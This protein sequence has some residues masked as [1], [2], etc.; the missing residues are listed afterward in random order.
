MIWVTDLSV[1]KEYQKLWGWNKPPSQ[2]TITLINISKWALHRASSLFRA[3]RHATGDWRRGDQQMD[4]GHDWPTSLSLSPLLGATY[5]SRI[6]G[7]LASS[8]HPA[9][10]IVVSWHCYMSFPNIYNSDL[11]QIK[12]RMTH[13]RRCR[14][15]F[16]PCFS[17]L[18]MFLLIG[19]LFQTSRYT[20]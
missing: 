18:I 6:A 10:P 11:C 4:F 12:I 20:L 8:F 17:F 9:R 16:V 2:K 13:L 19:R 15:T 14:N 7:A 5:C 1:A 3:H